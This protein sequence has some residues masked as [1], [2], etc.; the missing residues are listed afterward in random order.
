MSDP[1]NPAGEQKQNPAGTVEERWIDVLDLGPDFQLP[2][3]NEDVELPLYRRQPRTS[4]R[5][6]R[7]RYFDRG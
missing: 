7:A 6:R 2:G 5:R 3:T 1:K 4:R